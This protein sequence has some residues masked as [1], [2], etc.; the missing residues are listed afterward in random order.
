MSIRYKLFGIFCLVISLTCGLAFHGIRD[1]SSSGD[2]VVRLYDGP[3]MGINYARSAHAAMNEA[4]L[5]VHRSINEGATKEMLAKLEKLISGISDDLK[6]VRE[7]VVSKDVAAALDNADK[8]FRGW[9]EAELKILKPPAEGLT[10]LPA[11]FAITQKADEAATALDDLVEVVAAYGFSFRADAEASVAA[12]RSTMIALTTGTGLISLLLAV[13]FAYSMSKP[14]FAAMQVAER[15]AAGNFTDEIVVRQRDE[16]GRLLKSLSVMQASLKARA[17]ENIALMSSKDQ[18]H[19]EQ[20]S[21]RQRIEAEVA[22]FR[23]AITS[24]LANTDA[25]TGKLTETAQSLSS[26]AHA[27]GRQSSEMASTAGV[28]SQNVQTVAAAADQ[29]GECVESITT[30]LHDA[31]GVVRR[32]SVMAGA[33][34][35]TIGALASAAQHID[36]V[37]GFIR[38]IA[39][40]TNLLALNATIEAARAG[41]AGRG[42]AVVA[43]EVKALAIQTAKAT[44][45][46]SSQIAEVQ[47]ATKRAVDNVGAI[48][49]VMSDIDSFTASIARAMSQQNTATIEISEHIRQAAAGTASVAERIAGTAVASENANRSAELVLATAQELS[50]QAAELRSSVDHFLAN[51]AA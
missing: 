37:V 23:S 50:S 38:N 25:M 31:S 27:A 1:I 36:E 7:R 21:R 35:E 12:A 8:F 47:V 39:G 34:N 13:G 20:V 2:L 26:I 22:A 32:A 4:R 28:T 10:E 3:L 46:I 5:L 42:F 15:V 19:S 16:L 18:M 30:Q 44:E 29:L 48:T 51:A 41:E 17:D 40:Q 45:E 9:S 24:A 11:T 14:I 43:S 6:V 49:S 33:A